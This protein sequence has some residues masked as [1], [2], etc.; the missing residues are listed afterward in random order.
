MFC[1]TAVGTTSATRG[2]Y[3]AGRGNKFWDYLHQ[4]GLTPLRLSPDQDLKLPEY[5]IGLTDLVKDTA[6]SHDRGLDFSRVP[7]LQQRL[8]PYAPRW[9]AF[10]GLTAG[11]KAAKVFGHSKPRHGAQDW[12]I[13]ASR[14][15]VVTNPSGAAADPRTWDGR[16][17]KV[18]WWKELAA[19][20]A[21]GH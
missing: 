13:G 17:D 14:V 20:I 7:D 2:H 1:G 19:E 4:S 11:S 10:A 8:E 12:T 3:F 18:D 5:G 15:F 16:G 6:Q 9:V 21:T